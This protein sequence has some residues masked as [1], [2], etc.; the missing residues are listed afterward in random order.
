MKQ[1]GVLVELQTLE[2]SWCTGCYSKVASIGR[3][4]RRGGQR[5][6]HRC[7]LAFWHCN[8]IP[9]KNQL[10]KLSKGLFWLTV[11][12]V[13]LHVLMS[14]LWAY[15]EGVHHGG[16][17]WWRKLITFW[18]LGS[19]EKG[20]DCIPIS[21]SRACPQ[22]PNFLLLDSTPCKLYHLPIAT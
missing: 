10:F 9:E 15:G 22:W 19:K 2:L 21:P 1:S 8:K 12:K 18:W 16:S 20:R 3:K 6:D 11:S 14:L 13:S 4:S 5:L 7:L 17:M